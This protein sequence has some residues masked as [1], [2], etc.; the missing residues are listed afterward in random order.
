MILIVKIFYILGLCITS[1]NSYVV[2]KYRFDIKGL[3]TA[4]YNYGVASMLVLL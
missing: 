1:R 4:V 2:V 3:K